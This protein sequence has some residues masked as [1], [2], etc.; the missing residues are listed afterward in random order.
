MRAVCPG[1]PTG[2]LPT[3]PLD[4]ASGTL[5]SVTRCVTERSDLVCRDLVLR[6]PPPVSPAVTR[7]W[8]VRWTWYFPAL[9]V[10]GAVV[11]VVLLASVATN[12]GTVQEG[13][14]GREAVLPGQRQ[15]LR[16]VVT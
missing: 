10:T 14:L 5:V 12:R 7:A 15:L 4:A 2:Y 1:N 11:Q 8:T 9:A 13:R 3:T 6:G 16:D